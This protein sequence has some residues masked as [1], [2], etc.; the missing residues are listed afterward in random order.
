MGMRV[1]FSMRVGG[2]GAG[3]H[4]GGWEGGTGG[5]GGWEGGTGGAGG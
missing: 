1:G 5:A 3:G 4:A 2:K